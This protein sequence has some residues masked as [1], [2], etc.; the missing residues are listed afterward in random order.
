MST[1]RMTGQTLGATAA[2]AMLALGVGQGATPAAIAAL[3]F[4]VAGV[5]GVIRRTPETQA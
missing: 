4:F 2:A 1:G 3:L 5:L